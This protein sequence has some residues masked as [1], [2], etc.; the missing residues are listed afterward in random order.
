MY[1]SWSSLRFS[2][3]S[4]TTFLK[5]MRGYAVG[6]ICVMCSIWNHPVLNFF[7]LLTDVKICFSDYSKIKTQTHSGIK[8]WLCWYFLYNHKLSMEKLKSTFKSVYLD[9]QEAVLV[10]T[11]LWKQEV[12][13]LVNTWGNSKTAVVIVEFMFSISNFPLSK[14]CEG[15][16]YWGTL[17]A[18]ILWKNW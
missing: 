12:F 3:T 2:P 4:M 7:K 6:Q 17:L 14:H 13:L 16:I 11:E 1:H 15:D 18:V 5:F 8:L 10:S 9:K